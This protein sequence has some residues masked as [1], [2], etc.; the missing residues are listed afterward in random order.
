MVPSAGSK[1]DLSAVLKEALAASGADQGKGGP[2]V[3]LDK[4][5]DDQRIQI[6]LE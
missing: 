2:R 6:S 1:V 5:D 4:K 3:I